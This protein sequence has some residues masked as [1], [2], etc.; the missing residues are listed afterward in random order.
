MAREPR[1]LN[2]SH[3]QYRNEREIIRGVLKNTP[4]PFWQ[5][6]YNLANQLVADYGIEIGQANH[7]IEQEA[8]R[9]GGR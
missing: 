8:R 1:A 3:G 5:I 2:R 6:K 9:L 4:G 7:L